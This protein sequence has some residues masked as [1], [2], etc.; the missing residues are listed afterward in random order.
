MPSDSFSISQATF[1]D[2]GS[3][4][5]DIFAGFGAQAKAKGDIIEG[6]N[7]G[8]A[9]SYA[10]QEQNYVATSTAIQEA[11]QARSTYKTLSGQQA[12]VAGAGFAESGSALDLLR[13]S[14]SQG[15]I[16][17]A[18]LGQQGLITE[19][20]YEEQAQSYENMQQAAGIAAS[21][22]K[23]AA[24]GDF[25]AAG[26]QGAA[27]LISTLPGGSLNATSLNAIKAVFTGGS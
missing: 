20:G 19:Q 7:Y 1:S 13:S 11:Q 3:A 16:A 27:A 12:D 21:A 10:L 15:A 24:T 23:Q 8:L 2:A 18:V 4:V 6:Q 9:A 22:E 25:A 5:S 17:L 14:A 26:L